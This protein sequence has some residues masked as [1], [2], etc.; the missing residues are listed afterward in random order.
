MKQT[1]LFFFFA[2]CAAIVGFADRAQSQILEKLKEKVKEKVEKKADEKVDEAID[3]ALEDK[4]AA[5]KDSADTAAGKKGGASKTGDNNAVNATSQADFRSFSKFDFVPGE[6]VIYF[7]DFTQ[8]AVGDFPAKWNTNASGEIVTLGSIP[9]R[10]LKTTGD[11]RY[12]PEIKTTGF[13]DNYTIE[14]DMILKAGTD[15]DIDGSTQALRIDIFSANNERIMDG[16]NDGGSGAM[17]QINPQ[18]LQALNWKNGEG[19]MNNSQEKRLFTNKDGKPVHVSIWIQK[20]R[21]RL[22]IDENKVFDL[23]QFIPTG[24][25]CN[26]ISF[27]SGLYADERQNF[28]AN[29]RIAVGAPDMRSKLITDGRLVTRGILFD[30]NSDKIK[31]ASYGVL[32]EIGTVLKDNLTVRVKIIGHTDSDGDDK[33]NLDLSKRRAAS[34]KASLSTNFGIDASR[35]ETDGKGESQPDSPN[36]TPEGKANN[37]RVEFIKL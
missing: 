25:K 16:E 8:D 32:K 26:A 17:F 1:K 3:K 31:P 22:Y 4:K 36:T 37:R 15:I 9:G 21:G 24:V 6:Q 34:V 12:R 10:W 13:S 7:E 18:V 33:A 35:I 20:Q 19:Q 27:F 29:V 30:V 23:P 2:L 11:A 28:I 14:F 5:E